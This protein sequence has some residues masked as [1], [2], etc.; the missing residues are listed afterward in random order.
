MGWRQSLQYRSGLRAL[1]ARVMGLSRVSKSH[2]NKIMKTKEDR[3]AYQ[4]AWRLKN[5]EKV[6]ASARR[7]YATIDKNKRDQIN[8]RARDRNKTVPENKLSRDLKKKHNLTL[9]S[10]GK[11]LST[12]DNRCWI[13]NKEERYIEPTSGETR[14]LCIDH[15]HK[16]CPKGKSCRNCRRGLLCKSCNNG[17]GFFL[18][19]PGLLE[20]AISYLFMF[21]YRRNFS[22]LTTRY[23]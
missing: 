15:S 11:L 13:C 7:Y 2:S 14:R 9:E 20:A 19:D 16:C 17:L 23:C 12:Y 5:L 3:L 8:A 1:I 22:G 4:R 10:Y 18:D 21:E 6:R